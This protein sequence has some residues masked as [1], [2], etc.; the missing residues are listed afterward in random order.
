MLPLGMCFFFLLGALGA[1]LWV[2]VFGASP[3]LEEF[4]AIY[5]FGIAG[6]T[7]FT[8]FAI[9]RGKSESRIEISSTVE[10]LVAVNLVLTGVLAACAFCIA[11]FQTVTSGVL[12]VEQLGLLACAPCYAIMLFGWRLA[13]KRRVFDP[14]A[15]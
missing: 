3:E 11:L 1:L 6:I 14:L 7:S 10:G 9:L 8:P 5:A 15:D 2:S 4:T 12:G 13:Q